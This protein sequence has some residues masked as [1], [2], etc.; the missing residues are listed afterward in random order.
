MP[1]HTRTFLPDYAEAIFQLACAEVGATAQPVPRDRHGWDFLVEFPAKDDPRSAD[2]HDPILKVWVQ[3]KSSEN[4]G[5]SCKVTLSNLKKSAASREPWFI[6]SVAKDASGQ[7]K[8][9]ATHV[10]TDLIERTLKAVRKHD[11]QGHR[12]NKTL[13]TI[14]FTDEDERSVGDL[15]DWMRACAEAMSNYEEEKKRIYTSVGF[16]DGTAVGTISFENVNPRTLA[17]EFL[18]L[19]DG[20][21]ASGT[22]TPKRFNMLDNDR[23]Q[24]FKNG[25]LFITPTSHQ[26]VEIRLRG[27]SSSRPLVISG[28]A[29]A[30]AIF[31]DNPWYRFSGGGIEVMTSEKEG[32]TFERSWSNVGR[33]SLADLQGLG[34]LNSWLSEGYVD[35]QIWSDKGRVLASTISVDIDQD[36]RGWWKL[37]ADVTTTLVELAGA[38]SDKIELT[39]GDIVNTD[40]LVLFHHMMTAPSVRILFQPLLPISKGLRAGIYYA[41]AD[42]GEATAYCLVERKLHRSNPLESGEIAL[43]FGRPR[44]IESWIVTNADDRQRATMQKDYE[45]AIRKLENGSVIELGDIR[46]F[47]FAQL[48]EK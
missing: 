29:F 36:T 7:A 46:N 35:L 45:R 41:W 30:V 15:L 31:A 11:L 14:A 5:R 39:V 33:E 26:N 37:F 22:I 9:Y 25:T 12:L 48:Q 10:W 44:I 17:R 24:S 34:V 21:T 4:D 32:G 20:L 38:R 27:R 6:V 23:K 40:E 8:I 2:L 43:D 42:F 16:D 19:G 28:K 47:W 3:V 13:L 18:G 1:K